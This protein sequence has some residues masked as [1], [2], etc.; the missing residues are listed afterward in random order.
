MSALSVLRRSRR[1]PVDEVGAEEHHDGVVP[2]AEVGFRERCR[3][4]GRIRSMRVQPWAGVA[5]LECTV[6]DATGGLVVVFLGRRSIA[7]LQPGSKLIVEGMVGAHHGKL[8]MLNPDY[9]L[10]VAHD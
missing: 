2:I 7:G 9:R 8:A 6:V 10:L 5:T 3:I 4:H 1:D